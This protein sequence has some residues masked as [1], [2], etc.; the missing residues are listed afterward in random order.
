MKVFCILITAILFIAGPLQAQVQKNS[1]S[2]IGYYSGDAK[3]IDAYP[4]EKLTH[5]IYSFCHLRG[6][7]MVVDTYKDTL[8]LQHLV[9]LKQRN[10]SLKIILSI[11]GWG[12]CAPCSAVFNTAEGREEFAVS[13]KALNSYF[14][15]D[16][17]DLDWEY[18]SIE[19]YPGHQYLPADKHNFTL[20]LQALRKSM[21]KTPEISFAAGG[22]TSFLQSSV[23]WNTIAPLVNKI[24]LMSYDLTNGY[25]T[26]SGHHTPLYST[27]QL[28]ESADNAVR[29][30]DSIGFPLNKLVI[31][32]ATYGRIFEIF[33]NANNGLYQPCKFQRGLSFKSIH[34]D[35]LQKDGYTYY[36]DD[37]AKAPYLYNASKKLLLT[38]DNEKSIA[39]KTQY[40]IFKKLNGI[41]FWELAED[42]TNN[43]LLDIMYSTAHPAN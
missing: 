26:T 4:V 27:P 23:E 35:S 24:N 22:F 7:K 28:K 5:L 18:P 43:G 16:G 6:N 2:I 21:G 31:G 9:T 20:L 25:S 40:A 34:L 14:K 36:W 37:I 19:G 38:Y 1:F 39:L 30:L 15:T 41:M 33:N 42:K 13:V 17:I 10:P 12:G 29:Y 11:G 32:A 3:S 8:R